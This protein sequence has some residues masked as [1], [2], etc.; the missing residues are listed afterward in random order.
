MSCLFISLGTFLNIDSTTL[1]HKVCEHI[2]KNF[3]DLIPGL[4]SSHLLGEDKNRYVECMKNT[5]TW[6]GAVEIQAICQMFHLEVVVWDIRFDQN[7]HFNFQSHLP[8]SHTSDIRVVH[9]SWN[10]GHYSLRNEN[11]SNYP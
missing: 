3:K 10:G 1:R 6:G 7:T 4:D 9:L 2:L 11:P 5:T 8:Y